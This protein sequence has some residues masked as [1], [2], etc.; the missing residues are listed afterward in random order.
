[1]VDNHRQHMGRPITDRKSQRL[2]VP[3]VSLAS[4][5][6]SSASPPP[7]AILSRTQ[8]SEASSNRLRPR[9]ILG[10]SS[11]APCPLYRKDATPFSLPLLPLSAPILLARA[12]IAASQ[13]AGASRPPLCVACRPQAISVFGIRFGE[14]ASLPSSSPCPQFHESWPLGP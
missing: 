3:F 7:R 10:A 4:R 1:M 14:L 2:L 12:A 13:P 8:S 6:H 11:S 5:A 9:S